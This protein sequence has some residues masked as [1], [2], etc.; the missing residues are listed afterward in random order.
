MNRHG[1]GADRVDGADHNEVLAQIGRRSI[2]YRDVSDRIGT[3]ARI[4]LRLLV[5]P[6]GAD[7][8][9]AGA[10]HELQII[11]V[12]DDA[13]RVRVLEIDGQGESMLGADEAAAVGLVEFAAH[14]T[15]CSEGKLP[16]S[17][18]GLTRVTHRLLVTVRLH[19]VSYTHLTLPTSDL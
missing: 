12:I 9:G 7:H 16:R 17:N 6:G 15:G 18:K 13:R 1:R 19:A 2:F 8:V 10:L 11:C 14:A 5:D 4:Q 3:A